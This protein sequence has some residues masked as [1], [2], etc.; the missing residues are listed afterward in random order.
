MQ[1]GHVLEFNCQGCQQ[2]IKFSVFELDQLIHCAHCAKKYAFKDESLRRQIKKFEALC[3]QLVESEEILSMTS[4]GIDVGEHRVKVPYK[5]LLTRL[6]S[7]LDLNI[8]EKEKLAI[9]FRVEPLKDLPPT[10]L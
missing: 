6:N 5:I 4:V 10:L 1:K 9:S 2:P 8:G 7:V 3:R